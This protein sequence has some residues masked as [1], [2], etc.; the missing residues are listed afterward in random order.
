[1]LSADVSLTRRGFSLE[2][3]VS[4]PPGSVTA[5]FGP[6][7]A[8]KTTLLD[9]VAG[10]ARPER[11]RVCVGEAVLFDARR[12]IDL[13]PER[14]GMGYVFQDDR[15]F[16]HLSVRANLR[17]GIRR[18]PAAERGPLEARVVELL[19]LERL[20]DRRPAGLSGGE[21]QRV[22]IGRA[23]LTGP[24]VLL[25]DEPLASLD[26]AHRQ[27]IL[28]FLGRLREQLELPVLY[29][30]HQVGEIEALADRVLILRGGRIEAQG[31]VSEI[32]GPRP[33]DGGSEGLRR[34]ALDW[35]RPSTD[36]ETQEGR[37]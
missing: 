6:S 10:L 17:Y 19:A 1:M 5:L 22:T 35:L 2:A 36:G 16:P 8:G 24:R 32:L 7:G 21:R 31:A 18:V 25:L 9:T 33:V 15:L 4:A 11:G 23:L 28:E 12:G 27:E 34:P 20:L 3:S 30:T 14:R 13:P 37:P 29:V 26:Q